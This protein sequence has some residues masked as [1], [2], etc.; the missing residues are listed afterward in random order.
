M[1]VVLIQEYVDKPP[2]AKKACGEQIENACANLS[3]VE[4]MRT[5]K[6]KEQPQEP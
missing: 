1:Q 4:T 2:D 6:A 3:E 5:E